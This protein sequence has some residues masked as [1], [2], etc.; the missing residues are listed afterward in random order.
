MGQ[1]GK[2]VSL[3]HFNRLV[4]FLAIHL[5]FLLYAERYSVSSDTCESLC[6]SSF[7]YTECKSVMTDIC[8]CFTLLICMVCDDVIVLKDFDYHK[9]KSEYEDVLQSGN[10]PSTMTNRGHQSPAAFLILA[11]GLDKVALPVLHLAFQLLLLLFCLYH[12]FLP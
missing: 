11:S 8:G 1:L 2:L 4:K 5:R 9:G 10:Q 6:C 7:N 3:R 12:S